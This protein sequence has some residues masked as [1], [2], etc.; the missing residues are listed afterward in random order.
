VKA[1]TG[2][3][4]AAVFRELESGIVEAA[5]KAGAFRGLDEGTSRAKAFDSKLRLLAADFAARTLN[6]CANIAET[7]EELAWRS[8]DVLIAVLEE[9]ER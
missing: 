5:E 6:A 8:A 9:S 7:D 4:V 2:E 1:I 3:V